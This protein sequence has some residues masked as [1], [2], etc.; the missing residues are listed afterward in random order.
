LP[1]RRVTPRTS[2]RSRPSSTRRAT[3]TADGDQGL[4]GARAAGQALRRLT[5]RAAT[6]I[7]RRGEKILFYAEPKNLVQA[8]SAAGLYE[9]AMEIDIEVKPEK[10][11]P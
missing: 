5:R 7:S 6:P 11:E 10:G 4:H 8:K 1:R 9:P 2:R 3:R